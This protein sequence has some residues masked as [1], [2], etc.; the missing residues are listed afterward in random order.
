MTSYDC[1]Q[2]DMSTDEEMN[3]IVMLQDIKT[4]QIELLS[5]MTDILSVVSKMQE[6]TDFYQKQME[7]LETR[8]NVNEDNVQ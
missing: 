7:I 5:Q 6:N 1:D 4:A 2:D 3:L 8:M